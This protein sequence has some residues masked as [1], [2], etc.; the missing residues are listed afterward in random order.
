[1][2]FDYYAFG[3]NPGNF[4]LPRDIRWLYCWYFWE[5]KKVQKWNQNWFFDFQSNSVSIEL[6]FGYV[7]LNV[8]FMYSCSEWRR[9]RCTKVLIEYNNTFSEFCDVSYMGTERAGRVKVCV[10]PFTTYCVLWKNMNIGKTVHHK[11]RYRR[12]SSKTFSSKLDSNDGV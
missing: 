10:T 4:K 12:I 3:D 7:T 1:M 8:L 5:R 11:I 9:I 2:L 6:H